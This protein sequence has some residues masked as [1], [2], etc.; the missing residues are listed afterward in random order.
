MG[1][2][3]LPWFWAVATIYDFK[4]ATWLQEHT[5][6]CHQLKTSWDILQFVI[7]WLYIKWLYT[8]ITISKFDI[9]VSFCNLTVSQ[10]IFNIS[11]FSF[12]EVIKCGISVNVSVGTVFMFVTTGNKEL[13]QYIFPL[14]ILLLGTQHCKCSISSRLQNRHYAT[15][16]SLWLS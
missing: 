9:I 11:V 4:V 1:I 3:T 8:I 2:T 7:L 12:H 6:M 10:R 13:P 15:L 16:P 5:I 14:N